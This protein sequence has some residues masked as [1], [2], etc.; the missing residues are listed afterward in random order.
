MRISAD[1][2]YD[3]KESAFVDMLLKGQLADESFQ[4]ATIA[5]GEHTHFTIMNERST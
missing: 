5:D 4:I 3:E 2:L 1:S